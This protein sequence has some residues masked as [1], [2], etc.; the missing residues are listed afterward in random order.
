MNRFPIKT[1]Y[2]LTG[3]IALALGL[4]GC[5][6]FVDSMTEEQALRLIREAV[7]VGSTREDCE[8]W[9]ND[10]GLDWHYDENAGPDSRLKQRGWDTERLRRYYFAW[11][12]GTGRGFLM[13]CDMAIYFMIDP[14]GRVI[15][16][17]A[18]ESCTGL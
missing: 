10:Q 1:W 4:R 13:E 12:K 2:R 16:H 15:G 9:L 11:I 18:A 8:A 6:S 7:P 5:F 17:V 3:M 14:D